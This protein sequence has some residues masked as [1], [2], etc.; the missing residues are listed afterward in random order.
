MCCACGSKGHWQQYCRKISG[1]R[2]RPE[3]AE[4]KVD[5]K[6]ISQKKQEKPWTERKPKSKTHQDAITYEDEDGEKY[7]QTFD[8][9]HIDHTHRSHSYQSTEACTTLSVHFDKPL[10]S[11]G[12]RAKVDTGAA[13]NTLPL[14]TFKQMFGDITP[15]NLL[16]PEPSTNLLSYSGH[17]IP[18]LG[19]I[20]LGVSRKSKT[21]HRQ[22]KFFVTDVQ[23]LAIIGL[24]ACQ[25]LGLVKLNI[26]ATQQVQ[27]QPGASTA[28]SRPVHHIPPP[29][30]KMNTINNLKHWFPDCFDRIRC[31]EGPEQLYT[32]PNVE[33]FVDPPR[34]CPI[35]IRDKVKS[36]LQRME[37]MGII[38]PVTSHTDW[39]SSVTY[40]VKKDSSLR[41]C[42]NPRRL[43]EALRRCPHKIPT[44]EEISQPSLKPDISPSSTQKLGTGVSRSHQ[45]R[46]N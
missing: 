46:K 8:S 17:Q 23:G 3:H 4:S 1:G 21:D 42:L 11:E 29:E 44:I 26:D 38:R 43:N 30:T 32:K 36:E 34:R 14:R 9:I 31:F 40:A 35:H 39:C 37:D 18:C 28:K 16:T 10:V 22:Q 45:S 33:P 2:T 6:G 7:L 25:M 27:Q 15:S 20:T 13:W 24:P 12:L 19:S 41:I 5:S